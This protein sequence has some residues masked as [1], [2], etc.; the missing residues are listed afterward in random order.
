MMIANYK[1]KM[2]EKVDGYAILRNAQSRTTASGKP[3]LSCKLADAS[4]SIDAKAWDYPGPIGA[5]NNEMI[6]KYTG[7][8]GDYRGTPQLSIANIR[9][10]D[11]KEV[12]DMD[13]LIQSA[14]MD[15]KKAYAKIEKILSTMTDPDFAKL[16]KVMI[17]KYEQEFRT[18]P[19]AKSVHHAFRGGLLMHTCNMLEIAATISNLYSPVINRDLLLCGTLLHDIAKIKEFEISEDTGRVLNYS[20][21]GQLIG[22][23]IMGAREIEKTAAELSIPRE[24]SLLIQHMILSHHGKPEFGAAVEPKCAESELL[25]LIDTIDSRM[26]IYREVTDGMEPFTMSDRN[27]FLGKAIYW[28]G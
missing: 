22:H 18:F 3:Y 15:Q 23:L 17:S 13:Q 7:T 14:P 11:E 16:A 6:V 27:Q 28:H 26:E 9:L 5:E 25:W 21:E 19:A 2:G 1:N 12:V 4:G 20:L 8:V 24:K 10:R